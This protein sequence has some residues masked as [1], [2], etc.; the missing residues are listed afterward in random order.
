MIK[1]SSGKR[2]FSIKVICLLM[3]VYLFA[4]NNLYASSLTDKQILEIKKNQSMGREKKRQKR[5]RPAIKYLQ[6]VIKSDPEF[7][8][9]KS[10]CMYWLGQSY[11]N[12]DIKDSAKTC[13]ER[14]HQLKPTHVNVL[15]KLDYYYACD[16]LFEKAAEVSKKLLALDPENKSLVKKVGD[17]YLQH[18][19][20]MYVDSA[21][22][23]Y[24]KY[25]Q[26]NPDDDDV[27]KRVVF[28]MGKSSGG[29]KKDLQKKY[30]SM[31]NN[32]PD[33][34]LVLKKLGVLYFQKGETEKAGN[35]L[36]R[37]YEL[38]GADGEH[39][40]MLLNIYGQDEEKA[41]RLNI[42]AGK[43]EPDNDKYDR[44]LALLYLG[45]KAFEKARKHC[46]IALKKN[47]ESNDI[48][49]IWGDIYIAA[50]LES[51]GDVDYQDKLVYLIAFGL[52]EKGGC[53]RV[54]NGLKVNNQIPSKSDAFINKN[55]K[56]PIRKDYSWINKQWPEVMYIDTYLKTL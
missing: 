17:Y 22:V 39:I 3:F 50:V 16:K 27:S 46:L 49:K 28:L 15:R 19:K 9:A 33:D 29:D 55:I 43:M 37:L 36:Y 8:V 48:Y 6:K 47:P 25:L 23:W 18:K 52:Y 42:S 30:E 21:L 32:N 1:K 14:Y 20:G 40:R 2:V 56:R 45:R 13:Y 24:K 4:D 10:T 54:K 11:E 34:L 41:E 12:L 38:S 53:T 31:L 51:N 26:L 5:Y 7:K 44:N 35:L